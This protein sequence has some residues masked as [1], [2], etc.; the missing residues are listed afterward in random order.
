MYRNP[1]QFNNLLKLG[2]LCVGLIFSLLTY[3][4]KSKNVELLHADKM[5]GDA[6]IGEDVRLLVGNVKLKHESAIMFC[7]SAVQDEASRSFDAFGN[8]HII[9][10]DTLDIYS[11][12]LYYDGATKMARLRKNVRM[13]N[14]DVVLSTDK[15]NYD[16]SGE[17]GYYL[18][19]GQIQDSLNT[20]VSITGTYYPS[21][22]DGIFNNE[23]VLTTPDMML[24]TDT[25]Q[26][27]TKIKTASIVGPTTITDDTT[28]LYA[29][30]GYYKSFERFAFIYQNAYIKNKEYLIKADTLT[31]SQQSHDTFG[32]NNVLMKDTVQKMMT[33]GHYAFF[34][35][36]LETSFVT[37]SAILMMYSSTDT[38]FL[39]ADTLSTRP[40]TTYSKVMNAA[41]NVR[42]YKSDLQG[43]CDSLAITLNDTIIHMHYSPVIWSSYNQLSGDV[44]EV[45]QKNGSADKIVLTNDAFMASMEDTTR[46][47]QIKGK[48]ITANILDGELHKIDVDGNAESIYYT[49]D[50]PYVVGINKTSSAYLVIYLKD[51]TLDKIIMH[52]KPSGKLHPVHKLK[53][54]IQLL[55]GFQWH[56]KERPTSKSDIFKQ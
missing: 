41:Y 7:D 4:Q 44:I 15:L 8:V 36:S 6:D 28:L 12:V 13:I 1:I 46:F 56:F 43:K 11:D 9:Q 2:L 52:P 30:R 42:F 22:D 26:Y 33:T 48:K 25:L 21:A 55:Q 53:P 34:N 51:N 17:V 38:L 49:K 18:E 32:Y 3:G 10:G 16:L 54:E 40:D 29:E 24:F 20:I 5:R 35:D 47:N 45:Y 39:H 14:K 19:G 31:H 37:D 27:N 23:V 50:G